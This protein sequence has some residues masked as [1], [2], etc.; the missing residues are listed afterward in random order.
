MN[1]TKLTQKGQVTIPL[2]YREELNLTTG[3]VVEIKMEDKK[4][5][6]KKAEEN[7]DNLF[8]KWKDLSDESLK[9]LRVIWKGWN[10]KR[11]NRL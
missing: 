7:I 11:F 9:E 8:G 2:E 4:L 6:L 3:S 1:R 10:A 5:I